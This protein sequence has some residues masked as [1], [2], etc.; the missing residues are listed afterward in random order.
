MQWKQ[1]MSSQDFVR[2]ENYHCL[3][4]KFSETSMYVLIYVDD[5]IITG[6]DVKQIND[7]KSEMK[8]HF[9]MKDFGPISYY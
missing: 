1:Y 4:F 2:S 6:S 7:F 3:Y 9:K 8:R 5:L